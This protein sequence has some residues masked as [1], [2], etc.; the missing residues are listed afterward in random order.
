MATIFSFLFHL[1]FFLSLARMI[2]IDSESECEITM[3]KME[4]R[5]GKMGNVTIVAEGRLISLCGKVASFVSECSVQCWQFFVCFTVGY[6]V[7]GF[8][9]LTRT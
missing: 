6:F 2:D 8:F 7:F 4:I 3:L 5:G 9:F 1:F